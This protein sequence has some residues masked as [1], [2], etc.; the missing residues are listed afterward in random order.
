MSIED[1][2]DKGRT[3]KTF[4]S[5]ILI[6]SLFFYGLVDPDARNPRSRRAFAEIALLDRKE[7]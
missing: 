3:R 5:L 6:S 1:K 2:P 7:D 4:I